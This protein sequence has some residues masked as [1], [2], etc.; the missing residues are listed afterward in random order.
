[1]HSRKNM[2][3][4]A[5]RLPADVCHVTRHSAPAAH[6]A[7]PY[8]AHFHDLGDTLYDMLLSARRSGGNHLQLAGQL[9]IFLTRL[10]GC[11]EG[12]RA[13]RDVII[14]SIVLGIIVNALYMPLSLLMPS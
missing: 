2:A 12:F 10:R 14:A 6:P 5:A 9:E 7:A 11:P 8:A 4:P 1:M 13:H 3:A